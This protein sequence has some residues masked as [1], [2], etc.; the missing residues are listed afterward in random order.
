M[1]TI[2]LR[3]T[4]QAEI[5]GL[6]LELPVPGDIVS[7]LA[8]AGHIPHPYEG[9]NELDIQWIGKMDWLLWTEFSLPAG[10]QA[11]GAVGA[12]A[13]PESA[14]V[15]LIE[16][17]DTVADIYLNDQKIGSASN[18]FAPICLPVGDKL[19]EGGNRL[20]IRF[21]PAERE[22]LRRAEALPYPVPCSSYADWSPP[23]YNLLR[24]VQCHSGWD[25]GPVI[26]TSG[27]YGS[28]ALHLGGNRIEYAFCSQN[29]VSDDVWELKIGTEYYTGSAGRAA[30]K[31]RLSPCLSP[32]LSSG[33]FSGDGSDGCLE[34]GAEFD[35]HPGSN[36]LEY[37]LR[38]EN[39]RLWWPRGYGDAALY[40]LEIAVDRDGGAAGGGDAGGADNAGDG[41][42][43][44]GELL[45]KR[46]GFRTVELI[47]ADDDSGRSMFFRINGR[48]V[49]AK[50]A[51]WIPPD[52][53][54]SAHTEDR[55]RRL[56]TDAVAVNMNMLRLWGGGQYEKDIFY[57]LCDE[58][59]LLI[60]HD[61]MFSCA[62]YPA[63][64][65][66]L[67]EVENEVRHQIKRL[68]DHPSIALWCGNNELV[69]ALG[70]YEVSKQNRDR[71][72][73]DY[74]RLT[75]GII[76]RL[77]RDIDPERPW[78]PSS[79]SAG[80]NDYSD[81]WHNDRM[82]DMH[83]WSVWHEGLPL[84]SYYDV[85]PR[86]CSE[87]G[88]QSLPSLRTVKTFAAESEWNISS[89]V[90]LHH[91][92]NT[93][94]NNIIMSTLIDYFRMPKNF[95]QTLYLSQVQQALAMK[96]AVE[97]WRSR[98]PVNM[99]ALY[100]QLNDV[101]PTASWSSIEHGGR[102]KVLHYAAA[103]FFAPVWLAMYEKDGAVQVHGLNDAAHEAGG[104]LELRVYHFNGTLLRSFVMEDVFVDADSAALLWQ[105]Q[106]SELEAQS[107]NPEHMF[108]HARWE[109]GAE[110]SI[111]L[112]HPRNCYP[113]KSRVSITKG[114]S[115]GSFVLSADR[116]AFFVF[117]ECDAPGH[118]SDGAFTLLPGEPR[119]IRFL[120]SEEGGAEPDIADVSIKDLRATYD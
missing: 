30:L 76:G 18:L 105:M 3:G 98:R 10:V 110:N 91:Q 25:W 11:A 19:R 114:S 65:K 12:G 85:V 106:R 39:P 83:Y 66:F 49:Y 27:I 15:L 33:L 16:S 104:T 14:A 108:L 99:G 26:M 9:R 24:K 38:V 17:L 90:M 120:S 43:D 80:P 101:W 118:F 1:S 89:P 54:P 116:P 68:K 8:A 56:L 41:D 51:N 32:G 40:E 87:F 13:Q 50:G 23:H 29:R 34:A 70:W 46:I 103:R 100:W 2:D 64:K 45:R 67:G 93:R 84:E 20:E 37:V 69:G 35:V 115:R 81:C 112:S 63:D 73:V 71:Y 92:R 79:P 58:L 78:W 5:R 57:D 28:V 59:G 48:D 22:A 72:I 36:L 97:Y 107:D 6:H 74:D 52:A 62:L 7:A 55:Y 82:G 75:E 31:Y 96:M 61:M 53:L 113:E 86:F 88:F 95:E 42:G 4:W 94:G 44:G 119:E 117:P 77:A 111:F 21:S 47:A 60:W 102:W 109:A